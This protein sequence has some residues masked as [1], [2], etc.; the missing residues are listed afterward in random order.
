MVSAIVGSLAFSQVRAASKA[1]NATQTATASS[2]AADE[3]LPL[4]ATAALTAVSAATANGHA[5]VMAADAITAKLLDSGSK[6]T[7]KRKL[8]VSVAEA[9]T[10]N[11]EAPAAQQA[12]KKKN[13]QA[14]Q[15]LE[16]PAANGNHESGRIAFTC[17]CQLKLGTFSLKPA[18]MQRS[19]PCSN[20][21]AVHTL[22]ISVH[23][24]HGLDIPRA[25]CLAPC[26]HFGI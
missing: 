15:P 2:P 9:L 1:A 16:V 13:K 8:E 20:A 18:L 12:K 14:Q 25:I 22:P 6:A 21:V 7:K 11:A 3:Q 26:W 19:V 4:P 23:K 17:A 10:D 24:C 5:V